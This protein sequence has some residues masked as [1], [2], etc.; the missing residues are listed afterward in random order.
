LDVT[1]N[2]AL[3]E[4]DCEENQLT[5][6]DVSKN[7][8]LVYLS[9]DFNGITQLDVSKNTALR[10]LSCWEN[11]LTSLDVSKNTKLEYLDLDDNLF[12]DAELNAMFGTLHGNNVGYEKR[13][14]ISGNPGEY[15]CDV[16]IA[17][18]KGWTVYGSDDYSSSQQKSRIAKEKSKLRKNNAIAKFSRKRK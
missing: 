6:L 4:L 17:E 2:T 10:G 8:K 15:D 18:N 13:L 7:T 14:Y 1:K 16:S 3:V 12:S 11:N 9:C 5:S